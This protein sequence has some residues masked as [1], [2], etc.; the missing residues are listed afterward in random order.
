MV[1]EM[2]QIVREKLYGHRWPPR[3]R[4]APSDISLIAVLSARVLLDLSPASVRA[5]EYEGELVRSHLR[6]LYSVRLDSA[7]LVTGS[8][9][10]PLI[11]E[12]SAQIMNHC[13]EGPAVQKPFMDLWGLLKKYVE[14]GLVAQGTVGELIGRVLS[15]TAMDAAINALDEVC[16]LKYQTP[17]SVAAYYQA[18]LTDEAWETLRRSVPINRTALTLEAGAMTFEEAF[19]SAYFHF[20]HYA[21][22]NDASPMQDDYAWAG[23]LRVTAVLCQFN[24]EVS[25]RVHY[26]YFSDQGKVGPTSMSVDLNQDKT[27]QTTTS[28]NASTQRAED[29]NFFQHG[30]KLPYI[31]A[32]HCYGLTNDEGIFA[33]Q[34]AAAAAYNLKDGS[35]EAPAPCYQI[36]CI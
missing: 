30:N 19:D 28:H 17:V 20:S 21:K 4:E 23:W 6:M 35:G 14:D 10:E 1:H 13:I 7:V 24:Q 33:T 3:S 18:L 2:M 34:A 8:C 29:L 12:A 15:I 27:G 11:A 25:D 16:E 22:A 5:R 9:P 31:A 26:I 36:R 32:V